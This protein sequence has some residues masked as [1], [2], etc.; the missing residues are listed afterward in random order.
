MPAV[1]WI[2]HHRFFLAGAGVVVLIAAIALGVWFFIFR[3]TSTP[4]NLRQALRLY[5]DE[6]HSGQIGTATDLPSPGVYRYNTSGNEQLSFAGIERTFPAA[7]A[8][9]VTD[10]KCATDKWEPLEQHWEGIVVCPSGHGSYDITSSL[11]YEEIA[12]TQTTEVIDCPAGTY[13]VP[14]GARP[15]Q[16]W[17]SECHA[18]GL[19][20]AASGRVIGNSSVNVGGT[21]IPAI[22]TRLMLTFSGSESGDNPTD[23]WVSPKT[24]LILAQRETVAVAEKAG[25]IGSVE[26]NEKMAMT[27]SSATPAR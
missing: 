1:T 6:P 2:N 5:R 24:G 18:S 3:G 27:L 22:H 19:N 7:S 16:H 13:L 26:Y 21:T 17:R 10:K 8:M 12:G 23:Y 20:V 15:G 9:I 11:T 14:P 4:V 25:P